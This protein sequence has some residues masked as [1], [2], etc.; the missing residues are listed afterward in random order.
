[1]SEQARVAIVTGAAGGIG[2]ELVLGLPGK[3][4]GVAAV[5]RT[6]PGLAEL[7]QT[8][9]EKQQGANLMTI[10][11]DLARDEAIDEIV[12]K[13]RGHFG[14]IDILVN[15]AG[16][17]QATIRSDNRQNPVKFWDVTPEQW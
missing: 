1:M 7:A 17:G 3:E 11:A 15:N 12:A 9:Q 2:R 16:I 5:D 4:I 6:A 14:V 8:V 13:A 10:E